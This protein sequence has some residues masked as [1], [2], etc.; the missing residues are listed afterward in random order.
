MSKPETFRPGASPNAASKSH[1][2]RYVFAVGAAVLVTLL[3]STSYIL[4]KFAF[5]NDIGP[6]TLAGLRYA[7]SASTLLLV[8]VI[9]LR[10]SASRPARRADV[11]ADRGRSGIRPAYIFLLGLTGYLMAQGLQY[12]GQMLITP[13]QTSMVLAVGN[14]AALV[15]LDILW[16]REIRGRSSYLGIAAAV[17]GIIIF[18]YPWN[19]G[20]SSLKGLLLVLISCSGY[21]VHLALSRYL[22]KTG[23]AEPGDLVFLPMVIGAAG[24]LTL[25]IAL[26]GVPNFSWPLAGIL[27]WLG[28]VNGSIAFS[29]WTWSQKR[30][31]AYESSLINN[32]MLPEVTALDVLVFHRSLSPVELS[33]LLLAASAVVFVQIY[34]R[35]NRHS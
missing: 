4:N 30:L 2:E 12:A 7:V 10:L 25:G 24:M 13:T 14:T 17:A 35:F 22:L 21:A 8:R 1:R 6:F 33:G 23:K 18:Y 28:T 32:L 20:G 9:P 16:L 34:P 15:A 11:P 19:F 29:L 5:R 3:W 27:L 26:E 31:R